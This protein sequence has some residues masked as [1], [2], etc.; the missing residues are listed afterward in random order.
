MNRA[1]QFAP[2]AALTGHGEAI[3]ETARLTS[4]KLELSDSE[5]VRLNKRLDYAIQLQSSVSVTYFMP[6]YH[7]EGGKYVTASGIIKK[8]DEYEGSV[9]FTDKTSIRLAAI[10]SIDG[11]IFNDFD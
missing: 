5:L 1:A 3:N 11:E 8:I 9:I 6:D 10:I 4:T 2:F 7:K